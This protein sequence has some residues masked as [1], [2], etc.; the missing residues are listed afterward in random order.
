MN[1]PTDLPVEVVRFDPRLPDIIGDT[2][3]YD[4]RAQRLLWV[5]T[6]RGQVHELTG[7]PGAYEP[8]RTWQVASWA[9]AV[10]PR[11]GGGFVAATNRD[12]VV[13]SDEGADADKTYPPDSTVLASLPSDGRPRLKSLVCDPAGQL[14]A[15]LVPDDHAGPGRLTCLDPDGTF[16]TILSGVPLIGGCAWSPDGTT[17]YVVNS[18]L[19]SVEAFDY[20][21]DG[22][23][24]ANVRTV[25]HTKPELGVPYG[26]TVDAEGG[27]WLAFMYA[28]EVRRYSAAGELLASVALPTAMPTG[29]AFGGS[30]G[31]ELFITSCWLTHTRAV[32]EKLGLSAERREA[33][34]NDEFGGA[35]FV[36]RPGVSGPPA[37]A[38]AR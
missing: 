13:V 35:L 21:A 9:T 12:V 15:G 29:C 25:L 24:L 34:L 32:L 14:L 22:C 6:S 18:L 17:I 36:C 4:A 8:G 27:L 10:V 7:P 2:P 3:A 28:G 37:N 30:D 20:D 33:S 11:A 16:R 38:L 19:R 5:D 1:Q 23:R 26:V 31:T